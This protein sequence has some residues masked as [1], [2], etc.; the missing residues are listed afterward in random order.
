[1]DEQKFSLS[2]SF[3]KTKEYV[4]TQI[5][6]LKLQAISRV[7]RML[8]ALIVDVVKLLLAL[9]VTFF[10]ALAL[11]FYLGEVLGSNS[12]G[13]LSTGGVFLLII[14]IVRA[15]EPRIEAKFMDMAI[16]KFYNKWNE[17]D[18]DNSSSSAEQQVD[19][20]K[21]EPLTTEED[22]HKNQ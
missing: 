9:I 12:L 19:E 3:T 14:F 2:D 5:E 20:E 17:E 8:G 16:R 15:F 18:E 6:L 21:E 1:M 10:F 7:S 4:A 13:F 11:G 22:E